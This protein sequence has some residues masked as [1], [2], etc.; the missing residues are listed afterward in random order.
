MQTRPKCRFSKVFLTYF[1]RLLPKY[2]LFA[3]S[4]EKKLF[5]SKMESKSLCSKKC[6]WKHLIGPEQFWKTFLTKKVRIFDACLVSV[7][8]GVFCHLVNNVAQL[9]RNSRVGRKWYKTNWVKAS[10]CRQQGV[11]TTWAHTLELC[12]PLSTCTHQA[13]HR[14][15]PN[16]CKI[17][18]NLFSTLFFNFTCA[19]NVPNVCTYCLC[20]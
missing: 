12:T 10:F 19:Y 16:S 20:S 3:R 5:L 15:T 11:G 4:S 17:R 18:E 1:R 6:W 2:F 8:F 7:K 14:H 13:H 9:A